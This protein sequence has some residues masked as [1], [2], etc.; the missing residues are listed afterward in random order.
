MIICLS[1]F[2]VQ[3]YTDNFRDHC[4]DDLTWLGGHSYFA[5]FSEGWATYAESRIIAKDTD[6]YLNDT[7][8]KYGMI[9]HQVRYSWFNNN[10]NNN[11]NNIQYF[12]SAYPKALSALQINTGL[13]S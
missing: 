12:Y 11:N 4:S 13:I 6:S 3:G 8:S 5:S 1:S 9:N 10:D 2:K 7:M